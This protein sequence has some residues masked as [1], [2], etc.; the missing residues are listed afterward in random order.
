MYRYVITGPECSGKTTLAESLGTLFQAPVIEETARRWL[1]T[2]PGQ[3]TLND[4]LYMA[5]LHFQEMVS[6]NFSA[7]GV[8]ISDTGMLEF[9][10]WLKD[11]FD[12]TEPDIVRQFVEL[13]VQYYLLCEPEMEWVPDPLREDPERR[14]ELFEMYRQFLVDAE[15]PFIIVSGTQEQRLRTAMALICDDL[16]SPDLFL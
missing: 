16:G 2:H 3:Y 4:V 14:T 13:P 15:K 12:H 1:S 5:D 7:A 6:G 10:I 9:I 11:K 8:Q